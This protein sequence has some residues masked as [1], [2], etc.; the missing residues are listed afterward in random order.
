MSSFGFGGT[1]YHV[2]LEEYTSQHNL[3]YRLHKPS[4]PML[5]F[6]PTP[7][8]L[9]SRCQEIGQQLQ[10]DTGEQLYTELI[11]ASQSLEIPVT[12]ARLGFVADSFAQ[13]SDLLQTSIELLLATCCKQVLIC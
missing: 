12:S 5:L 3:P 2:V 7:G 8:E 10:S 9:L 1:N 4:Q 11:L 13:A 6:A